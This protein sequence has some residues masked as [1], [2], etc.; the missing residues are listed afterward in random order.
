MT[1]PS[2]RDDTIYLDHAA[3]TPVDPEVLSV[4]LPYFSERYGNPSSVYRLG[5]EGRAALDRARGSVATALGC[6][7]DEIIFTS[8]ATESNNLALKGVAWQRRFGRDADAPPPHV[9]TSTIEHHAVLHAARSLEQQGFAVT[10]VGCDE[11]GLIPAAAIAAA[12]RPETCLISVIYA[13]NEVGTIQPLTEIA[14]IANAHG[15]PFH[16]DAVQAAGALSLRANELGV[17]LLSLSAHKFYGPKGVGL[18]YVRKGTPIRFQQDGGG[19]EAGRRGGTENV[20]LVVGLA[21]A[22][23]KAEWLREASNARSASLRD[24]LLVGIR[25]AFPEVQ[26]NGPLD[27]ERRLANNL[28]LAIAGIE[29]ET[30]LLGLDM[31]GV[32]ASA[33]SACTTGNS[34]PSH[35]LRAMGYS[36]ERCR[37]SLRFTVGRDNTIA[38]IDE[39][40]DVIVET[41]NRA[42]GL[43]GVA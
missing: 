23:E 9:V 5:Q 3:T 35:V 8:G 31:Q 7:P 37:A 1:T 27:P 40:V 34:E 33:G 20:P 19:Q 29:G 30:V 4:M 38:E 13:N 32:A 15:I 41:V 24:Q 39:A 14:A 12:I 21:A 26:V 2:A 22:L 17:D 36:D 28:N 16:T 10:Y 6:R 25:E 43:A 18:L 11:D 42:R